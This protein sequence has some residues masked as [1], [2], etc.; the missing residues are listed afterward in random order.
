MLYRF[1]YLRHTDAH[2]RNA[3]AIHSSK[4]TANIQVNNIRVVLPFCRNYKRNK[5]N[6]GFEPFAKSIGL[7]NYII[8]QIS[9]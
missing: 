9:T 7:I 1:Q 5:M 2:T 6:L 8:Q 4:D 3:E